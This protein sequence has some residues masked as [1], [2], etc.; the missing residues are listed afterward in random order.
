MT[1]KPSAFLV[2]SGCAA[3]ADQTMATA[4]IGQDRFI[5]LVQKLSTA[6]AFDFRGDSRR[7]RSPSAPGVIP[8]ERKQAQ[9]HH[10]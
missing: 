6:H 9:R 3:F 2:S 4:P 10:Y 1:Q 7:Y 8:G 5:A